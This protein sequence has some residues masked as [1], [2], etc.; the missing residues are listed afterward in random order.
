MSERSET[1]SEPS[2][3]VRLHPG[4]LRTLRDEK[5]WT[6]QKLADEAGIHRRTVLKAEGGE[7]RANRYTV[8]LLAKALECD[9]EELLRELPQNR[10]AKEPEIFRDLETAIEIGDLPLF[11]QI[12]DYVNFKV[13]EAYDK[14][15]VQP[16]VG[17][18]DQCDYENQSHSDGPA[19][20]VVDWYSQLKERPV[21]PPKGMPRWYGSFE[22]GPDDRRQF[23]AL[24]EAWYRQ[25][26]DRPVRPDML[27]TD[28]VSP[29]IKRAL[30]SLPLSRNN[31]LDLY[32]IR[33]YFRECMHRP[34]AGYT[35]VMVANSET[36]RW[37]V[38]LDEAEPGAEN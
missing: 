6:Q 38:F 1:T 30:S 12:M 23:V 11:F 15:Q 16:C 18:P 5:G 37:A 35:L 27:L 26:R 7:R 32:R 34:V 17:L 24:L 20:S 3:L 4:N 9:P 36:E 19:Q 2:A 29:E 31:R 8:E 22:R 21:P 14:A 28:G 25:F 10:F 33:A 13:A